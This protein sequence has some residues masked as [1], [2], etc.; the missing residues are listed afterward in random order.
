ME[1]GAEGRLELQAEKGQTGWEADDI[2]M[3]LWVSVGGRFI[4]TLSGALP[5][6]R[7][8]DVSQIASQID[9]AN[10]VNEPTNS[11]V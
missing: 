9:S 1:L 4:P 5:A 10:K 8:L 7:A 6:L 3:C 11:L 2:T